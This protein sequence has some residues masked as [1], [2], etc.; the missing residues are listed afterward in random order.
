[1]QFSRKRHDS[2]GRNA[3]DGGRPC[4]V[5]RLAVGLAQQVALEHRP[6]GRKA[7]EECAIVPSFDHQRVHECKHQRDIGAGDVADPFGAGF[8]G[9]IAAQRADMHEFATARSGACHGAAL[10]MLAGAAAGHHAVFQR[11]T[12]EGEHDLA[13]VDDL[14]PGHVALGQLLVVADDMRHHDGGRT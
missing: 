13:V 4:R 2:V 5:L 6:A 1:V 10:D 7:V 12:A 11:H 3:G 9:Q 8:V 14:L